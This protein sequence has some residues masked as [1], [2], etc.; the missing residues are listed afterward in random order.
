MVHPGET[1]SF[2]VTVGGRRG[3]LEVTPLG[4]HMVG[5]IDPG[6]SVLDREPLQARFLLR[7]LTR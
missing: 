5:S 7:D 2:D 3:V 6:A 1:V 4:R